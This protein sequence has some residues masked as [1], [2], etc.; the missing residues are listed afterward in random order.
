MRGR[1]RASAKWTEVKDNRG[2]PSIVDNQSILVA[3]WQVCDER[4]GTVEP[5]GVVRAR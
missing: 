3:L 5:H 2:R 4:I 1:Q